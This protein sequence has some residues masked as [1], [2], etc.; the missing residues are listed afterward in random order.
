MDETLLL[1]PPWRSA[2]WPGTLPRAKRRLELSRAKH[3]SLAGH[4]RMAKRIAALI[5]GYAY[6]E[7]RF[8]ASDGA[9]AEVVAQRRAGFAR[10]AALY[11][12]S[13]T[14]RS[15]GADRRR[16]ARACPTCSSPA[17]Y[18][19]P[20]QYSPYLRE[21]LKIGSFVR[22][23]SGRHGDRPRR[24]RLLRPHRL[25]RRQRVRQRLLQ[26]LH[27]RRRGAGARAR[28]GAR[29]LPPLRGSTTSSG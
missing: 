26:G 28:P 18:R 21:H 10:L 1:S 12:A 23:S 29:R 7:Q 19:V 15:A 16:R 17:R 14:P 11:R 25:V 6:D 22:A 9:P 20:F 4:S 5:P 3:R 27:R 2:R 8:F 24:Q 13:A